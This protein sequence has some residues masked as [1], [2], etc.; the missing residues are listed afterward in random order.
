MHVF[1][2]S[3][4][5]VIARRARAPTR[6]Y[7]RWMGS[8]LP[9]K[10]K[11]RHPRRSVEDFEAVGSG[12]TGKPVAAEGVSW[13]LLKPSP[14]SL[15]TFPNEHAS[16]AGVS[17]GPLS[18]RRAFTPPPASTSSITSFFARPKTGL[19]RQSNTG[20]HDAIR[21]SLA[22]SKPRRKPWMRS[23]R[24]QGDA[25]GRTQG[26][27][28]RTLSP[29]IRKLLRRGYSRLKV[30]ELLTEQ[31]VSGEHVDVQAVLPRQD[32]RPWRARRERPVLKEDAQVGSSQARWRGRY[33]AVESKGQR[34]ATLHAQC[35]DTT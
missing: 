8:A 34:S 17:S 26:G 9:A 7:S 27:A 14:R 21:F 31:G 3:R 28:I 2:C 29:T 22:A 35:Q 19:P 4:K 1:G 16:W 15:Y 10:P 32:S 23:R 25:R 30:I 24:R 20:G 12:A 33:R 13:A 18:C 5:D 6:R 11:S